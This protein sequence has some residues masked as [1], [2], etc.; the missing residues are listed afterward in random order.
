[1]TRNK[2]TFGGKHL[3]TPTIEKTP[4]EQT[5]DPTHEVSYDE[6]DTVDIFHGKKA[7]FKN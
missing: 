5:Q 4:V 1:M 2:V 7:T 3:A 6:N